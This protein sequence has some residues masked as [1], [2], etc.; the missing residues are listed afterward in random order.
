MVKFEDLSVGDIFIGDEGCIAQKIEKIGTQNSVIIA[1]PK[2][3]GSWV[4][5]GHTTFWSGSTEVMKVTSITVEAEKVVP[6]KERR[7]F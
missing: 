5:A 7:T 6:H 4:K 2:S 1:P 3:T